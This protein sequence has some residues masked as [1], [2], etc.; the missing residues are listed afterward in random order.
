MHIGSPENRST[1][2]LPFRSRCS[3][4]ASKQRSRHC[5]LARRKPKFP[6]MHRT[7]SQARPESRAQSAEHRESHARSLGGLGCTHA[8]YSVIASSLL[9]P[10]SLFHASHFALP[11]TPRYRSYI[12]QQTFPASLYIL[13]QMCCSASNRRVPPL[14]AMLLQVSQLLLAEWQTNRFGDW[15]RSHLHIEHP[16]LFCSAAQ[17]SQVSKCHDYKSATQLRFRLLD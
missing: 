5:K 9:L 12:R 7:L 11:C 8:T 4:A 17:L 16:R 3:L 15:G 2:I 14:T 13:K 6:P 1:G 10:C